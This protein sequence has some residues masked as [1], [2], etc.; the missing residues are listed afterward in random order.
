MLLNNHWITEEIRKGTK[1]Y[2]ETNENTSK[3]AHSLWDAAKSLPGGQFIAAQS[4][5]KKQEKSQMK[6]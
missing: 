5:L 4:C 2:L 6:S 1:K 3:M